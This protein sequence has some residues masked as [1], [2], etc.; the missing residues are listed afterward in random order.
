MKKLI[1]T[2]FLSLG[3]LHATPN[4]HEQSNSAKKEIAVKSNSSVPST[5][6]PVSLPISLSQDE[7]ELEAIFCSI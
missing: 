3:V 2:L 6:S 5:R 1:L 4:S 7:T